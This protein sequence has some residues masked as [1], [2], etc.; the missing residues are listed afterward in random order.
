MK[1]SMDLT[2]KKWCIY[3]KKNIK[4]F[5][6]DLIKTNINKMSSGQNSY[7]PRVMFYVFINQLYIFLSKIADVKQIIL[8]F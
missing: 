4:L 6:N 8:Q 1:I 7:D 3:H 5:N 2:I